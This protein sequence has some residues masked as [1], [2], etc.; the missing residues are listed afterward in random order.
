M[1]NFALGVGQQTLVVDHNLP[2]SRFDIGESTTFAT[3]IAETENA[4]ESDHEEMP[5]GNAGRSAEDDSGGDG[6]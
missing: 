2:S 5:R 1:A 6:G 3:E 4:N